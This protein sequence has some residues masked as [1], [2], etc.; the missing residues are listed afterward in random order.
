[1]TYFK[2][3]GFQIFYESRGEG[4]PLVLIPGFASG[5]W[6]WDWQVEDLSKQFRVVT[7]DPRGISRSKID[8]GKSP[9]SSMRDFAEDILRLLD[10]LKIE[11]AHLLGASFGG[12]VAQEFALAFPDRLK[13]LI[14]ACT[15]FGGKNHV[16]ADWEIL[17][18]FIS[19]DD[20]N[21]SER[22]RKFMIPAFTPE[23]RENQADVVEKIF[24]LREENVVPEPVYLAQLQA[25]TTFD[26]EARAANIKAETLVLTGDADVVV[27]PKNS[28][29]LAWVVPNV[30]LK[31]IKGGS[32]MFF[33]EMAEEFNKIVSQ[34]V[35]RP[36]SVAS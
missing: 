13:K 27:P 29:N 26:A 24:R 10:Y 2:S 12:F 8:D 4:E 14:L 20:L 31:I 21:K 15:S 32:H 1:M 35:S 18:A 19:T 11:R 6:A 25:A 23:F 30:K 5:A 16:A 34:F 3:D 28:E 33:V 9:A 22:I 7:F 36:L 17:A